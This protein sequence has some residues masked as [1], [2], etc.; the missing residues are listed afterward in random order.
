MKF[1]NETLDEAFKKNIEVIQQ[2]GAMTELQYDNELANHL[3][4]ASEGEFR[5]SYC[6]EIQDD[7]RFSAEQKRDTLIRHARQDSALTVLRVGKIIKRITQLERITVVQT[8]FV[9]LSM[10]INTIVLYKVW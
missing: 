3:T 1:A 7:E 6:Y 4:M 8:L 9:V 10:L 2:Y 5:D